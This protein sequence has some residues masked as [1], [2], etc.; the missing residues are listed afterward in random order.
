MNAAQYQQDLVNTLK[1][2]GLLG[3]PAV[4]Q[5]F[6]SVPRHLFLPGEPLERVYS[7]IAI[8]VRRDA[9]GQWTSSSSQPAIMAIM[10]EQLDLQPG[11]R[12]LEVGTGT[13]FN[14][15]L[16][17]T[18]VGSEGLVVTLDIQPDLV[19]EACRN[20]E[21][22]GCR[23][24]RALVEDGGHGYPPEAPY[25][26]IILTAASAVIVP[27]WREQL[28]PG[29]RLVLPLE[30]AGGQ[31]SVAFERRG[32]ELVSLSLKD[33][34]FMWLQGA[35]TPPQ[36][37]QTPLGPDPRLCL[38]HAV[39]P[40]LPVSA[41]RFAEWLA[42]PAVDWPTG[43]VAA[44]PQLRSGLLTWLGLQAA[45]TAAPT[46]SVG[47]SL[48]AQGDLADQA[49]LPA[50]FGF[51]GEWKSRSAPLLIAPHGAAALVRTPGQVVPLMDLNH[52]QDE[53]PFEL[54]VRQLG[55]AEQAARQLVSVIQ[56]WE[57]SG[58]PDAADWQVRAIPAELP[59]QLVAG[60]YLLDRPWT[61]LLVRYARRS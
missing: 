24:V 39:E 50:L 8:V 60:E 31:H 17:A 45:Q 10:L 19:E 35:Y 15:A 4:E 11:Q 34:G 46:D 54:Y 37:A 36:L 5:A 29:G 43:V 32:L 9:G 26:R 27:A 7:D 14:A 40:G 51:G 61:R 59:Y 18:I 20:L 3:S 30:I 25:D 47:A 16:M 38:F 13:G 58:R 57:R 28:L 52:P 55:P 56:E 12:V 42:G 48:N 2:A 53:E 33:C 22:A 6:L 21:A 41:G 44:M 23:Q 1:Q 49:G